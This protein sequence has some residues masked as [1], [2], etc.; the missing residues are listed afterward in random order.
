M[1]D[2][3]FTLRR[4][5]AGSYELLKEGRHVMAFDW[6]PGREGVEVEAFFAVLVGYVLAM[7]LQV[8]PDALFSRVTGQ[9]Y[10]SLPLHCWYHRA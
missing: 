4:H 2:I 5:T 3:Q 8:E 6:V 1:T 7:K 10:A 9:P